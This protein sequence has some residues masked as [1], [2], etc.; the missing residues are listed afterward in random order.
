MESKAHY[1][2]SVEK[3]INT[4]KTNENAANVGEG[5]SELASTDPNFAAGMEDGDIASDDYSEGDE[6]EIDMESSGKQFIET[7]QWAYSRVEEVL[8]AIHIFN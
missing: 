5:I 7:G 6:L 2:K 4:N 1:K 8:C 3:G